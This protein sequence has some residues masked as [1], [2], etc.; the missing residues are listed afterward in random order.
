MAV[1]S[2]GVLL[3]VVVHLIP[4]IQQPL[5]KSLVDKLGENGYRGA[6]SLAIL[7]ALLMIVL[8][9]RSTPEQYL[10][11][12]PQWSRLAGFG[13]MI[14]SFVLLGAAHYPTAIKRYIRHPMLMGVFLW[15]VSHLLTNGTGRALVLFGGLGL[16][17]LIEIP[18][19]NRREGD[20]VKPEAPG[21]K[22]EFMGIIIS[23]VIF[24][25]T[26]TLHPYF[27]G[28]SPLPR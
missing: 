17:A 8:G 2:I 5:K 1:L 15:A 20:Y 19:I 10:Y 6:F 26:L 18:L 12:L 13:L 24:V 11:I 7:A 25:V 21:A 9:W 3:W 23:A 16:W 28:V 27:A 4:T 22:K 14:V